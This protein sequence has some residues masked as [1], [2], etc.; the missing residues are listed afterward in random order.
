LQKTGNNLNLTWPQGTL[1]QAA[2]ITGPWLAVTNAI[3]PINVT[4]TNASI[5]YRVL[6]QQ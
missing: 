4:P 5:F 3:S 6:L 2:S 1:L